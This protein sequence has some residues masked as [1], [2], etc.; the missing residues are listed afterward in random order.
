MVAANRIVVCDNG[1]GVR[2]S[3]LLIPDV[4]QYPQL[5]VTLTFQL[6]NLF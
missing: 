3:L 2:R 6:H 1:T 5:R 4:K